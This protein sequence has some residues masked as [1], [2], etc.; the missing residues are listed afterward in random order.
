VT[1]PPLVFRRRH[2]ATLLLAA[3]T[4]LRQL[5]P[6]VLL[7]AFVAINAGGRDAVRTQWPILLWVLGGVMLVAVLVALADYLALRFALGPE[8]MVIRSGV[9]RRVT[10]SIPY[11]RIQG[12]STSQTFPQRLLRVGTVRVD[13]GA[14]GMAAEAEL[15]VL[16]W[17]DVQA[18]RDELLRARRTGAR[19][20]APGG[21]PADT[22]E[23]PFPAAHPTGAPSAAAAVPL[24]ALDDEE[25][26]LA[27]ATSTKVLLMLGALVGWVWGR[28]GDQWL[29]ALFSDR[30]RGMAV[31]LPT[32]GAAGVLL[33]VLAL[34]VGG[35]LLVVLWLMVVVTTWARFRGFRLSRQGGAL[36][37]EYGLLHRRTTSTPMARVQAVQ[38]HETVV[39]RTVARA[40]VRLHAAGAVA[41]SAQGDPPDV[42]VLLP[43]VRAA[44]ADQAVAHVFP[45]VQLA[46]TAREPVPGWRRAS[47][48]TWLRTG[49]AW[50]VRLAVVVGVASLVAGA[51]ALRLLWA[52]PLV[53]A[54][55]PLAWRVRGVG[56]HGAYLV[57]REGGLS[58]TTWVLPVA[59]LQQ[60]QLRQGPVQRWLRLATVR[61]TTAGMGGVADVVDLPLADARWLVDDLMARLPAL[62]RRRMALSTEPLISG[63]AHGA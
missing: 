3:A 51:G 37:R 62:R 23:P 21:A 55:T 46:P 47:R 63:L 30:M 35:S 50:S 57:V 45:E 29:D 39:R 8:A 36:V 32:G 26:L 4:F 38:V 58:R 17:R 40:E 42:P 28:L 60:V 15:K 5:V 10:R 49:V 19:S 20:S 44:E 24:V 27:G 1:A 9:W 25:L 12:V 7:P 54:L 13:S 34:V 22:T 11:A 43:I 52:L 31:Q 16:R 53:W 56:Q 61:L 33:V 6:T 14:D 2:P 41:V 18:L 48:R 59:K